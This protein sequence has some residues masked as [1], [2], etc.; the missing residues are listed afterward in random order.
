MKPYIRPVHY[1]ETDQMAVVHHANYIRWFEEARLD[2]MEQMGIRY[3]ELEGRGILIP[4]VDVSCR[5]LIPAKYGDAVSILPILTD[6]SGVKMCFR[7]EV[8]R[9][10]DGTLLAVGSSSHCFV[11][12][13]FRPISLK[14]QEPELHRIFSDFLQAE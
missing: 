4:V 12:S 9:V 3:Q 11:G 1:Y 13:T 10:A 6:Y 7:Y 8:R 2:L 5:Y 14:R